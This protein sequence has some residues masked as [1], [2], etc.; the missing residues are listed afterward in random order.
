MW[1]HQP[2][3]N[4]Q[5]ILTPTDFVAI[6][7]QILEQA[8]G[9]VYIQGELANFRIAKNRWV[10][11]DI[12]DE[13]S[14][15]SCFATVYALPGPLEEGMLIKVAGQP[16][17]HPLFGF[18]LNVQ[19]IQ[20][21]GEG[22]IKKAF[23]LLKAAL[24]TEGLFD[25]NRK[26]A[27]PYPPQK[28]AL[29]TS[30]ESAAY[31]DFVKILTYRWPFVRLEVYDSQ[32]QG[33]VAPAQII[34]A[35]SLA[36]SG[37]DLADV[38]VITRGGGNADDLSAFDDERV[39]R[40]IASSRIPTLVAIGHEIDESLSELVADKRASTPSNAAELLVPDK[41]NEI[42]NLNQL[43]KRLYQNLQAT[44][45]LEKN[46]IANLRQIFISRLDALYNL[47]K[48]EIC[49]IRQLITAYNPESVLKRGYALVKTPEGILQ[50]AKDLKVKDR[51]LVE[52]CDGEFD[53]SVKAVRVKLVE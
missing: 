40:A 42:A 38:L 1:R 15:V 7:N 23:E 12:K 14:K 18:S 36:N 39:V 21:T 48:S 13:L 20:P 53:A 29:I 46:R 3:N 5:L 6:T 24:N 2:M 35:L 47:S 9:F 43:K 52:L 4:P 50:S 17:L 34:A 33:E 10:Y 49:N 45:S 31:A 26:R 22:A 16:R 8:L 28:V 41:I 25:E 37:A 27:L 11:F 30:T 32:V 19:S 51:V 44:L